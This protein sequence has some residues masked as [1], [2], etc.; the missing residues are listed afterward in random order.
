[1]T[2]TNSTRRQKIPA[3]GATFRQL[4]AIGLLR[5]LD[6]ELAARASKIGI[7]DT[8]QET[9]PGEVFEWVEPSPEQ[10]I[11]VP[12]PVPA[13]PSTRGKGTATAGSRPKKQRKDDIADEIELVASQLEVSG[14]PVTAATVM[15]KLIDRVGTVGTCITEPVGKKAVLWLRST[16][17]EEE[18][19]DMRLLNQRLYNRR[20]KKKGGEI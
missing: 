1:M 16:T 6:A 2:K 11:P 7:G 12:V 15:R 20:K 3:I 5:Q 18:K 13:V 19:L 8:M 17:G 14:V 4:P 9:A 10:A